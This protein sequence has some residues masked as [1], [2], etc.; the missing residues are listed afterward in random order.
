MQEQTHK[1]HEGG[2]SSCQTTTP[3]RIQHMRHN[4]IMKEIWFTARRLLHALTDE[5]LQKSTCHSITLPK[6][7]SDWQPRKYHKHFHVLLFMCSM[8]CVQYSSFCCP[9]N[10]SSVKRNIYKIGHC[11][12][13][14][15]HLT[16]LTNDPNYHMCIYFE[17]ITVL[18]LGTVQT[19]NLL[20]TNKSPNLQP[21]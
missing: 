7:R 21:C 9:Q 6:T 3:Q 20:W 18:Q 12:L 14:T 15:V 4:F 2:L 10:G 16:H 17:W 13:I 1:G 11:T 19:C 5:L 8:S